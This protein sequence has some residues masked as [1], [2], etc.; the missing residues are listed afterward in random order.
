M[1]DVLSPGKGRFLILHGENS[2]GLHQV[3]VKLKEELGLDDA[4]GNITELE[5]RGL[6][7]AELRNA[8]CA[9]AFMCDHR[10]IIIRGLLERFEPAKGAGKPATGRSRQAK[11]D[12]DDWLKT[13][14]FIK[15]LP[16]T[17]VLVLLE[18][19][20]S[21]GKNPLFDAFS[22]LAEGVFRGKMG[23]EAVLGWIHDRVCER[24]GTITDEAVYM[25]EQMIGA[26]LW[27]MA[28]EI[29]KLL[30]F[31]R[32]GQVSG[33][34]VRLL[35][36]E[37]RDVNV[38]DLV[39]AILEGNQGKSQ[40]AIQRFFGEGESPLGL[41]SRV[42]RQ[43][44]TIAAATTL[45]KDLSTAEA[46]ARLGISGY[47]LTKALNQAKSYSPARVQRVYRRVLEA[48]L[49]IKTGRCPDELALVLLAG[50]LAKS[51]RSGA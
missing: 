5:G 24:G 4:S 20:L 27:T 43:L 9:V 21:A 46:A 34:D 8:C 50:D 16:P 26:D 12:L 41:L 1:T 3:L 37:S 42:S 44:K 40:K 10:L 19:K 38:F 17:T 2:F 39:D 7:P 14:G 6:R 31:R 32:D 49:S 13:G 15:V 28:N 35:V 51:T 30:A 36:S 29:D 11:P 47:P 22:P 45:E 48:D 33:E 25:L 18:G 23:R